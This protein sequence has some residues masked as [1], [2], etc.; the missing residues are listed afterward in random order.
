MKFLS[1]YL[2]EY[3]K[4]CFLAPLFKMLEA[5]FEL[6]VPLVMASIIDTGIAASD[7]GY[8]FRMCALLIS[9][10]IVGLIF[11]VTAQFFAAK[12]AIYTA[13]KMRQDMFSHVM[14][15]SSATHQ[16]VGTASL[17][18]RITSDINQVQNSINLFLRLFLRSPFIVLGAMI[19]AATI[20]GKA[21]IIFA[22]IIILL[23]LVVFFVMH[24]TLPIFSLIQRRMEA[25]LLRVE[26]N[27]TGVRV[28]RAFGNQPQ[29]SKQF[30]EEAQSLRADQLRAGRISAIL[31]PVTYVMVNLGIV[32]LLWLGGQWVDSGVLLKGQVV[33]LVNYMSQILVE[34]IKL[35]NLIVLLM[36][37]VPCLARVEE[38]MAIEA[39]DR[40]HIIEDEP[41]DKRTKKAEEYLDV[42][43]FDHVTF[44][45]P[46][47]AEPSIIDF[48]LSIKS[49]QRI[50]II[51]GTGSGK[52]TL[53]KLLTHQYDA[54]S[55]TLSLFG[56]DIA[57]YSDAQIS[58]RIG[59]VF[60]H[61]KLF[62]MSIREN[63]A[64]GREGI[65]ESEIN[66]AIKWAQAEDVIAAKTNGLDEQITAN[67]TNLSGGQRQRVTIA[68]A[69]VG[70]PQIIILD[71]AASALDAAT[72]ANLRRDL[73][74]LPWKPTLIIS[75]Q[76]PSAVMDADC[77]VV[78]EDGICVG[79]GTHLQLLA[80][81]KIY[82]E[83]YYSQFPREE[84]IDG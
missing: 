8:V 60:Q 38:V 73:S 4:E 36:R 44:A 68:R 67:A 47:A 40:R 46:D 30:E 71:D 9:F 37:G 82:Q 18:T 24:S 28:I 64:L 42:V 1:S 16:G 45:Y 55:G 62:E 17:I 25:L 84:A 26:E 51:G 56:R 49:G 6:L 14:H 59:I 15:M 61:A 52:S 81:N 10:A 23:A 53:L 2:K 54:S 50:G 75:S 3:K 48:S 5:I 72:D 33:A 58:E 27:I 66:D 43:N 41:A 65:A 39:D 32:A 78:M 83:I 35:A 69:L 29:Q 57:C 31:N 63:I 20:D 19:M 21:T 79:C 7:A 11:A 76:R 34:L 80:E 13:A 12:A 22:V 70:K 77:I 74:Q